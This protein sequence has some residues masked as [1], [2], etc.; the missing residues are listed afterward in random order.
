MDGD[1]S[2]KISGR[3]NDMF[4][5]IKAPDFMSP[6]KDRADLFCKPSFWI[7]GGDGWANDIGFAGLDHVIASGANVNILVYDNE[8]YANTGFQMS[9]ATPRGAVAKFAALGRDKPKKALAQMMLQYKDAYIANCAIAADPEQTAKAM[10]EAEAHNGPSLII[11][12]SAC[13]GHGIREGMGAGHRQA[14]LAVQSGYVPLWRRHPKDGFVLDSRSCDPNALKEMIDSEVRYDV[15]SRMN[16]E[17][18]S[19]LFDLIKQDVAQR[20]QVLQGLAKK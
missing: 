6:I 17:R 8:S 20:W 11:G 4:A 19:T 12:Y 16:K 18:F 15:L 9:K 14:N 10:K 7:I 1:E 3:V 2:L 5:K 13:I